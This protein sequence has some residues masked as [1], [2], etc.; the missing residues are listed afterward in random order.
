[1]NIGFVIVF[2]FGG[3]CIH[4]HRICNDIVARGIESMSIRFFMALSLGDLST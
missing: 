3:V 2:S 1:M 4:E